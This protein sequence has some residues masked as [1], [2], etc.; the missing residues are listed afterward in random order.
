MVATPSSRP[1]C[2]ELSAAKQ[3]LMLLDTAAKRRLM[4]LN[5]D[6]TIPHKLKV[7]QSFLL[8]VLDLI[9]GL[10]SIEA[11]L[12]VYKQIKSILEENI[13]LINIKV[14][15][16]DTALVTLRQKLNQAEQ[17]KD[18]LKQ[19]L[20]KFQTS[21]KNLTELLASQTNEKHGLGYLSSESDCESLSPS[22]LSDK[23][24]PTGGFHDVP[25]PITRTFMPPKPD[26]V[27]YTVPINVET[28]HSTFTV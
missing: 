18:D 5:Q 20:D 2:L 16:R 14:Q 6:K 17:E 13:K 15:A 24:Q 7:K 25:P 3:K 21:S 22:P 9:Q 1:A 11:R 27:F 12:V 4:L 10:E 23:S 8:V 28:G 26:L 19:K